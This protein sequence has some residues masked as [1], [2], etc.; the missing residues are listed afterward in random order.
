MSKPKL[1]VLGFLH[2]AP[3]YGYQ[4]GHVTESFGLPVWAG[5]KLPSIY[6]A[7]QDL[8]ASQHIRGEQI[9]EG[10]NPPR[11]V[12]HI[13][14]KGRKFLA[15]MVRQNLSSASVNSQDWWL[16]LSFAW[17]TVSREFLAEAIQNRLAKL[18]NKMMRAQ[19]SVYQELPEVGQLPFT[20]NHI[21]NL[22]L[23]H[24]RVEMQTLKELLDD[25][26]TNDH[27]DFFTDKG[28]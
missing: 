20:H 22:G 10:N 14:A 23:R 4:I 3:M 15:E 17:Q 21:L 12:F 11:T 7:L 19:D 9:T 5:I 25:V 28:V 1:V 13:N 24:H 27:H 2:R 18:K 16:T 8:D 26:L 6:K